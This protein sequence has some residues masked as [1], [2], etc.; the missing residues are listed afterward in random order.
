M[1]H[2]NP[3]CPAYDTDHVVPGCPCFGYPADGE[4]YERMVKSDPG[5]IWPL[6]TSDHITIAAD[7]TVD[8]EVPLTQEDVDWIRAKMRAA[9]AQAWT[10]ILRRAAGRER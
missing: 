9:G 6:P 5:R 2:P 4:E 8:G 1:A 3:L 10:D 7:L